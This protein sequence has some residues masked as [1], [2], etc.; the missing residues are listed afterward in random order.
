MVKKNTEG[1]KA[2][3]AIGADL[4][5]ALSTPKSSKAT[6]GKRH[7]LILTGL[8]GHGKSSTAIT[9][10]EQHPQEEIPEGEEVLITDLDILQYD[11]GGSD[12]YLGRGCEVPNVYDL[13]LAPPKHLKAAHAKILG[14]IKKRIKAG[15]CKNV[16]VD[17]VSQLD[18][19]FKTHLAKSYDGQD[20]WT[21]LLS[22]H[23]NFATELRQLDCNLV[24]CCHVKTVELRV[25]KGDDDTM[26]LA[27]LASS[28]LKPGDQKLSI[29]G[30]SADWYYNN[31][32][33]VCP[34]NRTGKGPDYSY[35]LHPFGVRGM[36]GKT[37][38][39]GL[40]KQ[41]EPYLRKMLGAA[42]GMSDG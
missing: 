12:A 35:S 21:A 33:V 22:E 17:S 1:T 39:Q 23:M 24:V 38:F 13:S 15:D 5:E 28:D 8:G 32:S 26:A 18:V 16:L 30:Q 20:L 37:R 11:G 25:K 34:V 6:M 42:R 7:R 31:F 4:I 40:A 29:T 19:M 9:I 14:K 36:K 3:S 27:K 2:T 10:S 41:E